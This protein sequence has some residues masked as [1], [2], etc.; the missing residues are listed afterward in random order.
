MLKRTQVEL[1]L[2]ADVNM[3]LMV[4]IDGIHFFDKPIGNDIKTY[5]NIGKIA[6]G[7]GDDY[8]ASSLPDDSYFKK[9]S[10]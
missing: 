8:T 3:L 9:I 7:Q 4:M 6:T 5:Q 2:L 1:E 10:S